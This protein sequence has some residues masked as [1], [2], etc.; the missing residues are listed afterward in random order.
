M[1]DPVSSILTLAFTKSLETGASELTKQFTN[2]AI[3]KISNLRKI[4]WQKLSHNSRATTAMEKLDQGKT[5]DW[6]R[7]LIYL[8]DA[9]ED[10][11]SFATQL[12]NLALE[13]NEGKLEGSARQE[14]TN[15]SG[16]NFQNS[17]FQSE[18]LYQAN[19]INITNQI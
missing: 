8:K 14:Q 5:E 12:Q 9:M 4:I 6:N 2:T 19:E 16:T 11:P 17:D 1:I 13:I 10:D 3:A 7:L 18:K 15:Y